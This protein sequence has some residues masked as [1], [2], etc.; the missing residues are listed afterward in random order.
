MIRLTSLTN[1]RAESAVSMAMAAAPPI[2]PL[3]ILSSP[4]RGGCSLAE[5]LGS[6]RG[7]ACLCRRWYEHRESLRCRGNT[8]GRLRFIEPRRVAPSPHGLHI[9]GVARSPAHRLAPGSSAAS[10][11][12]D[13]PSA[14]A[15]RGPAWVRDEDDTIQAAPRMAWPVE[16]T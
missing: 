10:R 11:A 13:G 9:C 15:K 6:V 4:R 12:R 14:S 8:G 16:R 2:P 3:P 5:W 1:A 7:A